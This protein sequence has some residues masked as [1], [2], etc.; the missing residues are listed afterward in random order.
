MLKGSFYVV[1]FLIRESVE[2][3]TVELIEFLEFFAE[4]HNDRP[5]SSYSRS[6]MKFPSECNIVLRNSMLEPSDNCQNVLIIPLIYHSQPW[7]K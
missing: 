6:R 7:L 4:F 1:R 3:S 2:D 5:V